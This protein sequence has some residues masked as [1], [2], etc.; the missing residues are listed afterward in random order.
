MRGLTR[1][2]PSGAPCG[3]PAPAR[4]PAGAI[5]VREIPPPGLQRQGQARCARGFASLDP[6]V[7]SS[8]RWHRPPQVGEENP[9]DDRNPKG[10]AMI[11]TTMSA[12]RLADEAI[13]LFLE[14]RDIHG[15]SEKDAQAAAAR[16]T[17]QGIDA[18]AEL[19]AAGEIR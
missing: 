6:S 7:R 18:E 17:Q 12:Y 16:D 13:S 9:P 5:D 19:R 10:G 11:Q 4:V 1:P 2:R 8:V 3:N 14:Y 15:Y